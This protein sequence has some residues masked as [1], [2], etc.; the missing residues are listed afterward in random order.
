MRQ[1]ANMLMI[2][3]EDV[4]AARRFYEEGLGWT[5]WRTGGSGSVMYRIGGAL[6]VFLDAAFLAA[7]RGVAVPRGGAMSLASF[8]ASRDEVEEA[9][10]RAVAAGAV[11]T[12]P[13]RDRDGGLYSG[14]F[15]D[16]QGI[17]WEI[18]WSPKMPLAEDGSLAIA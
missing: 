13:A 8:V 17:S 9:I 7:E 10:V 4:A 12:S 11:V 6:L 3:V 1:M 5:A 16:P 15:D 14:Y 2:G 18:V